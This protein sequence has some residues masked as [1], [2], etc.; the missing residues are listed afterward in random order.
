MKYNKRSLSDALGL[1]TGIVPAKVQPP[2]LSCARIV[3]HTITTCNLEQQWMVEISE[4]TKDQYCVDAGRLLKIVKAAPENQIVIKE[5][6]DHSI[7]VMSGQARS[8]METMPVM[9]FPTI[10]PESEHLRQVTMPAATMQAMLKPSYAMA[11]EDV[12]YYLKGLCLHSIAG[13]GLYAVASDGVRLASCKAPVVGCDDDWQIILPIKTVQEIRKGLQYA[14]G[15]PV[16]IRIY[17]GAAEIR[18]SETA[19]L[20]TKLVDGIFPD[21]RRII[22]TDRHQ[23]KMKR[24]DLMDALKR[25]AIFG[26]AGVLIQVEQYKSALRVGEMHCDFIESVAQGEP[27]SIGLSVAL[28]TGLVNAVEAEDITIDYGAEGGAIKVTDGNTTHILMPMRL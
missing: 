28:I 22:P 8:R 20:T 21:W 1:A 10:T 19:T 11:I 24:D 15:E 2:I 9:D 26:E 16:Q 17:K 18:F 13:D 23:A 5:S 6:S 3:E 7:S 25:C 14:P 27:A 12:R 4:R